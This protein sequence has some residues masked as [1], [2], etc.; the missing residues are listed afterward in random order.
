MTT[1]ESS[2]HAGDVLATLSNM[3]HVA[4]IGYAAFRGSEDHPCEVINMLTGLRVRGLWDKG[5]APEDTGVLLYTASAPYKHN[6]DELEG[7]LDDNEI[8]NLIT[9]WS[10]QEQQIF[11]TQYKSAITHAG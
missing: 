1:E 7:P 9:C 10:W 4:T 3:K 6:D 8:K 2:M 11:A 5:D